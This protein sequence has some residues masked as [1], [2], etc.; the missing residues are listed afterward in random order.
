MEEKKKELVFLRGQAKSGT[1]WVCNILNNHN[2]IECLGEFHFHRIVA[3]YENTLNNNWGLLKRKPKKFKQLFP[4][5]LF[6][7][8]YEYAESKDKSIYIDRTPIRIDKCYFK[9]H[10]YVYIQRD[11]RDV[12]V[13][14]VYHALRLKILNHPHL[15]NLYELSGGDTG[16]LDDNKELVLDNFQFVSNYINNWF[17][18]VIS[19]N[20]LIQENDKTMYKVHY[21]ELHSN[22]EEKTD[23][24][25][26]FLGVAP[27]SKKSVS[28]IS[29]PGLGKPI[30]N[31]VMR[32][33]KAG[34]WK[35]YFTPKQMRWYR[36]IENT[37]MKK[38]YQKFFLNE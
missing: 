33:G 22:Y 9:D 34:A 16:F 24:L 11:V 13:S 23:N 21:E 27:I 14:Y 29:K 35:E 8:V 37:H 18:N 28:E 5:F 7:V 19:D 20:L 12:V 3:G 30:K 1:N 38:N 25:Y 4:K 31:T 2:D 17:Q 26:K 10:K 36:K 6:D 32:R 15:K